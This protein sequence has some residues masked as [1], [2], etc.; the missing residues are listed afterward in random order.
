MEVLDRPG[1]ALQKLKEVL[2]IVEEDEVGVHRLLVPA[3]VPRSPIIVTL[4][5]RELSSSVTSVLTKATRRNIP[6]YAILQIG[7][8]LRKERAN[9][10]KQCR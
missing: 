8:C 3:N 9:K 5:M 6:E 1:C 4:M 10:P 2:E 7:Q